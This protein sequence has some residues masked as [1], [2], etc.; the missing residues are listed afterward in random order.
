LNFF[1]TGI[2]MFWIR[3]AKRRARTDTA[4]PRLGRGGTA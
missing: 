4:I 3:H 2:V 1:A